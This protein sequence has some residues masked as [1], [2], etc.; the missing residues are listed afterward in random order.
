MGKSRRDFNIT[1]ASSILFILI[2][3]FAILSL[4]EV[5]KEEP[6]PP[7]PQIMSNETRSSPTYEPLKSL[8]AE[9]DTIERESA[10]EDIS[11]EVYQDKDTIKKPE[12][13]SD[14]T[15]DKVEMYKKID[16]KL[17]ESI[18]SLFSTLGCKIRDDWVI[19]VPPLY[20]V[21][22]LKRKLNTKI[23]ELG[24]NLRD[25][26]VYKDDREILKLNFE[27]INPKGRIGII[28]D[29]V[30]RSTSLNKTL[31][32]IDLPLNI[33]IL[34]RQSRS[35][36]MSIIGKRKGWDVLLHLPMEP[37]EKSW[38]DSTFI[39][40]G[41][42][43]KEIENLVDSYL[44]ELSYINGVNNHM[45]SLAT[46]DERVMRIVLSIVKSRGL[47]FVDSLTS[48]D[49]VGER[50]SIEIGLERFAK[51]D[52]F[53]DNLDDRSYIKSQIEKLIEVGIRKGFAIGI[54]HLRENT[55]LA[56]KDYNWKDNNVEL[57]LLSEVL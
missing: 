25:N 7:Q 47:Y 49:S 42:S 27:K 1:F 5:E 24:Y 30:G 41:M 48:S 36:E 39:K 9:E 11:K 29:D 19:E 57:V 18:K 40:V 35:K 33:S 54:G 6:F 38:I 12:E 34:P 28:I 31:Q 23:S 52:I 22:W 37:K 13:K 8:S 3:L 17:E 10:N 50:V 45:G 53:L 56:I 2:C 43:D 26:I 55:L 4:R 14:L 51:R 32:D 44:Q 20:S 16:A 21:E 46:M 15:E